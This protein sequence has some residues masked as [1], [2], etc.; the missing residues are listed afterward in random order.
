MPQIF[1]FLVKHYQ[2]MH[3]RL[4]DIHGYF[5]FEILRIQMVYVHIIFFKINAGF[6]I[7]IAFIIMVVLVINFVFF[8]ENLPHFRHPLN[9]L[10]ISSIYYFHPTYR[11][12]KMDLNPPPETYHLVL[13]FQYC[14]IYPIML[15]NYQPYASIYQFQKIVYQLFLLYIIYF[16]ILYKI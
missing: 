15:Q 6:V 1:N 8:F 11:H 2:V 7:I 13:L 3:S 4:L 12:F 16:N 14:N 5:L 10:K 9:V